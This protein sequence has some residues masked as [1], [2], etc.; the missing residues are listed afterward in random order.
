MIPGRFALPETITEIADAYWAAGWRAEVDGS[1]TA[2]RN[3]SE[4]SMLATVTRI[5]S[6]YQGETCPR[7]GGRFAFPVDLNHT[8]NQCCAI[9][10][11]KAQSPKVSSLMST[12]AHQPTPSHPV[13]QIAHRARSDAEMRAMQRHPSSYHSANRHHQ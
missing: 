2:I 11:S 6:T 3:E 8:T 1:K 13:G 5:N 7:C 10:A 9:K 12:G 4:K